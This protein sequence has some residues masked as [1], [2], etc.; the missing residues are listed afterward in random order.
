MPKQ[1]EGKAGSGNLELINKGIDG[2]L[3]LNVMESICESAKTDSE[4]PR[5]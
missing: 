3:K 5:V 2:Y 1:D 4:D